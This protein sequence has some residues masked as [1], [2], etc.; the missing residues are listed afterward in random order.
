MR[1]L[2][3]HNSHSAGEYLVVCH[4]LEVLCRNGHEVPL[5]PVRTTTIIQR[6][7][8][9]GEHCYCATAKEIAALVC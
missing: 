5:F 6:F 2:V 1:I 9:G 4:Q 7:S 3:V 8:H